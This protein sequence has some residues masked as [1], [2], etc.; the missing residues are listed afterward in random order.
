MRLSAAHF[1]YPVPGFG[2]SCLASATTTVTWMAALQAVRIRPA[3]LPVTLVPLH[4]VVAIET[5]EE[6]AP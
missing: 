6:G 5:P 3:G 4:N 2:A 1:L